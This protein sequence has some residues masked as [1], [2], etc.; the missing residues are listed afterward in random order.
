MEAGLTIGYREGLARLL[1]AT[2][3]LLFAV[4]MG[5]LFLGAAALGPPGLLG[6]LTFVVS[7]AF[8]LVGFGLAL[9]G[10][11]VMTRRHV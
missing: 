11:A 9:D 10:F 8:S 4:A 7:F 2:C 6:G 1:L 5:V 3:L